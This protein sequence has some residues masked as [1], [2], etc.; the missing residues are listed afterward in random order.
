MVRLRHRLRAASSAAT[1]IREIK[2]EGSHGET[3]AEKRHGEDK[4][5]ASSTEG[6]EGTGKDLGRRAD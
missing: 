3:E 1:Q 4:G 2:E 6:A 5:L